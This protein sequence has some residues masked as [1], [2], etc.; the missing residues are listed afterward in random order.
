[1]NLLNISNSQSAV[2]FGT[3]HKDLTVKGILQHAGL[4]PGEQTML[5]LDIHNP[6][7]VSIKRIDVCF[8]Q[9][10]EIEQCRRRLELIRLS[11]PQLT[12]IHDQHIEATCPLTIPLGIP[13]SFSYKSR[14]TRPIVHVDLHY[15][16]K[17]E[18]KAK[19]LFTDFDLQVPL[20]IGTYSAEHSTYNT[21][22]SPLFNTMSA[23]SF[24]FQ[25]DDIPPPPYESVDHHNLSSEFY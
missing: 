3:K 6:N 12:N 13:P 20:I 2:K 4:I 17:L 21:T 8:I 25:D 18:I 5:S 1:V 10:Y 7:H 22:A 14:S 15:D 23:I 16:L 9:R 19:G 11:V 24:D